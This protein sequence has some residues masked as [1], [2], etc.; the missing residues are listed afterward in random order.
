MVEAGSFAEG[1]LGLK[2]SRWRWGTDGSVRG[3]RGGWKI[4][5]E[6]LMGEGLEMAGKVPVSCGGDGAGA[7]DEERCQRL[8][9][10]FNLLFCCI[11]MGLYRR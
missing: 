8:I 11:R 9:R 2:I 3:V 10:Q 5:F 1:F 6:L 7:N 4:P